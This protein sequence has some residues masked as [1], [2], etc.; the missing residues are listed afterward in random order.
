V[1]AGGANSFVRRDLE[2]QLGTTVSELSNRFFWYGTI[3]RFE[4][5]S[6]TVEKIVAAAN[7]SAAWYARFADHMRLAPWEL[8]WRYVQRSGRVDLERLG[9]SRPGSSPAIGPGALPVAH[10]RAGTRP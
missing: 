7:A 8:A 9:R 2:R 6:Q 1:A 5:L 3:R 4:S 10:G